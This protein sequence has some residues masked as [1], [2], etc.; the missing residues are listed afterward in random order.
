MNKRF[1]LNQEIV[2]DIDAIEKEMQK[3]LV[4]VYEKYR[5]K[6]ISAI[7]KRLPKGMM[8]H[9]INGRSRLYDKDKEIAGMLPILINEETSY[10]S[11]NYE[12]LYRISKLQYNVNVE[13]NLID[14]E[15]FG[16][17]M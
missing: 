5:P 4:K 7:V 9:N 15:V 3:E 2:S 10:N 1:N 14:K 8:L 11:H 13:E 16:N 6:M 17:K 12:I